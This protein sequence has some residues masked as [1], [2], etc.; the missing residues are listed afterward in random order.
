[1]SINPGPPNYGS[2]GP[3]AP[4]EPLA[5]P[6]PPQ[7]PQH[8]PAHYARGGGGNGGPGMADKAQQAVDRLERV[9]WSPETK[10]FFLT[11]EFWSSL[12]VAIGVLIAALVQDEFN[13][14]EA[15]TLVTALS[16]GYMIARGLSRAG[17]RYSDERKQPF[18]RSL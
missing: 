13:A 2:G 6:Y 10:P 15:W 9:G 1:M 18:S 3:G 4:T 16:I 17:T 11:S 14:Q 7:Q 5:Q 8:D 12:I